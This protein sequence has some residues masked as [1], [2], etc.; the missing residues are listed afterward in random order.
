MNYQLIM[1]LVM[2]YLIITYFMG[3]MM[4]LLFNLQSNTKMDKIKFLML[5]LSPI[6]VPLMV[7]VT[8]KNTIKNKN[9]NENTRG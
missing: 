7:V 6:L 8:I 5:F 1:N 9:R 3:I 4:M 2:Y